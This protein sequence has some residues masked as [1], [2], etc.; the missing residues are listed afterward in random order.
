MRT[1]YSSQNTY[2]AAMRFASIF[3]LIA[4]FTKNYYILGFSIILLIGA[5]IQYSSMGNILIDINELAR[6]PNNIMNYENLYK[7]R[8]YNNYAI[9][10][11]TI[12]FLLAIF[13]QFYSK[14]KA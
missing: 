4:A 8:D 2:Y 9:I 13:L 11:Y 10:F 5:C 3:G 1:E 7:L 6:N 12:I 14:S